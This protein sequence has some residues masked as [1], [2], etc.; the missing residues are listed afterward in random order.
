MLKF[1]GRAAACIGALVA[2]F[3]V[4]GSAHAESWLRAE[5][6][7]F[8]IY[9]TGSERS[10]KAYAERV[11]LMDAVFWEAYGLQRPP[12]PPRKLPVY[13]VDRP[14]TLRLV[15]PTLPEGAVGFYSAS[16]GDV[17][18]MG[19]AGAD[20]DY[21]LLHEYAHH[22][23]LQNF[24]YGYPAW[25]VEGYAEYFMGTTVEDS[26]I[27]VGFAPN[28][29]SYELNSQPWM[30]WADILTKRVSDIPSTHASLFYAQSWLLTHYL[31]SDPERAKQLQAYLTAIGQG[32]PSVAAMEAATGMKGDAWDRRLVA[33]G[34]G[35]MP[36]VQFK[37]SQFEKAS[38]TITALSSGESDLLLDDL[39]LRTGVTEARKAEV[40]ARVREKAARYPDDD[41][42]KMVL[43]RAEV[44]AGDQTVGA[45]MLK[46][47]IAT[48][49]NDVETLALEADRLMNLGDKTPARQAELYTQAGNILVAAFKLNPSRYQTLAAFAR[50]RAG[51]PNYP[52]DNT[53]TALLAALKLAPQVD[54]NRLLAAEGLI[55]RSR[56][57]EA[58]IVLTPLANSPHDSALSKKAREMTVEASKALVAKP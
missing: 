3:S 21:I 8:I 42:V 33:Y 35:Q 31:L 57:R 5:T 41:A 37:R 44:I 47:R 38:V 29:R 26:S 48:H 40:I 2:L 54:V 36:Y 53:L 22:L 52:S 50:S 55:R 10:L 14:A 30:P 25:L 56:Q 20:N 39:D 23:M 6:P 46:R 45:E 27:K 17:F 43:A 15:S 18:A 49:P 34:G 51:E 1:V 7:R 32:Q 9:S 58:M 13:L 4:V 11:E 19:L 28:G 12:P 16:A 24:P